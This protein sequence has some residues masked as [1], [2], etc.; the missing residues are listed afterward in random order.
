MTNRNKIIT[1][2]GVMYP[3]FNN[4]VVVVGGIG[5]NKKNV[6]NNMLSIEGRVFS[7]DK[8]IKMGLRSK[9]TNNR[10]KVDW[11]V[12]LHNLQPS[13]STDMKIIRDCIIEWSGVE[14]KQQN[15]MSRCVRN[16]SHD[17]K[18]NIIFKDSAKDG[19]GLINTAW[20]LG[21]MGYDNKNV[22]IVWVLEDVNVVKERNTK[23]NGDFY[24]DNRLISSHERVAKFMSDLITG[25]VD[26]PKYMD[27][28]IWIVFDHSNFVQI[29]KSG[30]PIDK[31]KLDYQVVSL[32]MDRVP[33]ISPLKFT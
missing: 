17:R 8:L 10:S 11:G 32:L 4:V 14:R 19:V 21:S 23:T 16:L 27:G 18:P 33:K 7:D 28:D 13:N 3:H 25:E 2:G 5:T 9:S 1:L 30:S 15:Y 26:I 20:N 24:D 31:S 12:E 6:V 29:K 22:H